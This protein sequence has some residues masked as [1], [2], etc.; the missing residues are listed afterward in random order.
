[1][2]VAM[3]AKACL[4]RTGSHRYLYLPW[5]CYTKTSGPELCLNDATVVCYLHI[6]VSMVKT[7]LSPKRAKVSR[8]KLQDQEHRSLS[9]QMLEQLDQVSN[10]CYSQTIS[11]KDRG[12]PEATRTFL[13]I[14]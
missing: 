11:Q 7:K 4:V 14:V 3:C 2:Q 9:L 1:M 6:N 8:K 12:I 10:E 13:L 5:D